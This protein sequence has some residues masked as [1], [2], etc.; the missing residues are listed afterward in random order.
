MKVVRSALLNEAGFTHAFTTR[1]G[2]VSEGPF[3]SL[4]LGA[5]IGD[6]E[7][8][9][10]RNRE[11]LCSALGVDRFFHVDQVHGRSVLVLA[12]GDDPQDTK[13]I[14]ADALV[15]KN[16]EAVSVRVAD[17]LPLLLADPRSGAVAAV[18]CGWR[19]VVAGIVEV[20]A[21]QLS[22]RPREWLAAIGPHI[23]REDFEIGEDVAGK[24]RRATSSETVAAQA[25]TLRAD[26]SLGVRLQLQRLGVAPERIEDVGGNSFDDEFFSYRRDK[27][28][29]GRQVGLIVGRRST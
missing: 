28:R 24:I 17:C 27:G 15:A 29:T 16:E 8:R 12:P 22:G 7:A 2:G 3:E 1:F 23:R 6:E 11:L 14:A 9:V 25:G 18:H 26:L 20:V 19:G 10:V 4:N 5:G 21:S 13:S